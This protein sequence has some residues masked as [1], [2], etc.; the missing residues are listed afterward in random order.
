[1]K[2]LSDNTMDLAE[3]TFSRKSIFSDSSKGNRQSIY[4]VNHLLL[5]LLILRDIQKGVIKEEQI[6]TFSRGASIEKN[7]KRSTKGE[8]GEKRL[9]RD[10][11]NQ[12][13]SLNAPDC[14]RALCQ[15]YGGERETRKR[16]R[17]LAVEL[18]VSLKS[19]RSLTGRS[20]EGQ[21]TNLLDLYKIGKAFLTLNRYLFS[22]LHNQNHII[23]GK[24]YSAQS[25]LDLKGDAI[26]TIFWGDNINE[27]LSFRQ[28]QDDLICT[29]VINGENYIQTVEA[30]E[31]SL[32]S[33]NQLNKERDDFKTHQ[34]APIINFLADTYFGEFYT[35][36]RKKRGRDDALQRYGYNHSF[37]KIAS[38]MGEDEFNILTYEGVLIEPEEECYNK[39]KVFYLGGDAD[40]TIEEFKK[41]EINLVSLG[42][43]H[44]KD[45]GEDAL[46]KTLSLFNKNN[47]N[48]IGAGS[49]LLEALK[50]HLIRIDDREVA[51]FAGYWYRRARDLEFDFYATQRAG[52]CAIDGFLLRKIANFKRE[53]PSCL[54]VVLS[55]WG[56]DFK[57][58]LPKQR[59]LAT[60]LVESGADLII[61]SGP[62]K[63]QK[64]ER[65]KDKLVFYSLGNGIFNSDGWDLVKNGNLPYSYFIKF[66]VKKNKL[67]IYPF[68]NYNIDTFWQPHFF[69]KVDAN[70]VDQNLSQL[71]ELI[72]REEMKFDE[73][74]NLYYE[75]PLLSDIKLKS[76]SNSIIPSYPTKFWLQ[77][78]LPG[79]FLNEE[80]QVKDNFDYASITLESLRVSSSENA[81][82]IS[83]SAQDQKS[84][85]YA[86]NWHPTH[87]NGALVK[88]GLED[89]IGLIITDTPI[90]IYH[91]TI[92]QYIVK[93][94]LFAATF[95]ADYF[96]ENYLGKMVTITGSVGKSSVKDQMV[97]LLSDE[98]VVTN[99]SSANLHIA[100]LNLALILSSQPKYAVIE[101]ALGGFNHLAYGNES[102]RYR[103]DV[104]ILTSFGAAHSKWGI[105]R[106]LSRKLELFRHTTSGATAIINA[107][108]DAN[109]LWKVIREAQANNL[110]I[111]T[112]SL[113]DQDCYGYLINRRSLKRG[114]EVNVSIGEKKYS[115]LLQRDSDGDIQNLL[116]SL[117]ALESIDYDYVRNLELLREYCS[118][119]RR[120]EEVEVNY[121]QGRFMLIDDSHNSS[122]LALENALR[123]FAKKRVQYS[124]KAI[125]V[126]GEVADIEGDGVFEHNQLK[127]LILLCNAD[128]VFLWGGAFK[129]LVRE[130]PGAYCCDDINELA[131]LVKTVLIDD[132]VVLVKGS[133]A[134]KFYMVA[135]TLKELEQIQ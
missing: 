74:N 106:N 98:K 19:Q 57:G 69:T 70:K 52:V 80:I 111:K 76:H 133:A 61:G 109:Y 42:N 51:F 37:E 77:R 81:I 99:L 14:L 118:I 130:I 21:R 134:S 60:L 39:H 75:I 53:N 54:I 79:Y 22:Y 127:E 124:G 43:N 125:L 59:E 73:G 126:L 24:K 62:H 119:P 10:V 34:G 5:Y 11:L 26:A 13:V 15:L 102:Y 94:T 46:K 31:Q 48:T 115:L 116:A 121:N 17:A 64:I 105:D 107:D 12:A 7:A 50:P 49:N 89:R 56:V 28:A 90:P 3:I 6:I 132:S 110:I 47:I 83:L 44:A 112:Y 2:L 131:G 29:I 41:R 120:L 108:I 16:L 113:V 30:I 87:M 36:R 33:N 91:D 27:C 93:D 86:P 92:P 55:H 20:A 128:H 103:S 114:S 84:L 45:Y 104:V 135:D 67:R 66:F 97:Y 9:L 72:L 88:S 101:A 18:N 71:D 40:K 58:I 96:S 122:I 25:L 117:I 85:V 129:E 68:Y 32:L 100:L 63:I 4:G 78:Y 65:I 82:F 23:N 8:M 1:M 35:D 123:F 38:K 95:L